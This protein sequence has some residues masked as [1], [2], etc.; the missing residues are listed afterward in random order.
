MRDAWRVDR[1][2]ADAVALPSVDDEPC[3]ALHSECEAVRLFVR[4]KWPVAGH[5]RHR[6]IFPDR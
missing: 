3:K 1:P 4:P 6:A 5:R 2:S